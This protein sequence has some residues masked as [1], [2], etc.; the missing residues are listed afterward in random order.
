MEMKKEYDSEK[1][2]RHNSRSPNP[3]NTK[4]DEVKK[5]N[6]LSP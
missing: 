2:Y 3:H 6:G 1:E 4:F 5:E